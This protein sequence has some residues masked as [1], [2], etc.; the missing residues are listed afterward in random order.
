MRNI[1][2]LVRPH[3]L[4]MK[5][6]SS[7]R[8]E[9]KDFDKNLVFL[10]AN[11]SPF[12]NGLNRY[13][14]PQQV[15]VKTQLA[16]LKNLNQEQIFLGNGS[17]EVLDLIFR[18]FCDPNTDYVITLP[19]TYG[20][21]GVLAETNQIQNKEILLTTDFQPDTNTIL[22]ASNSHSKLLFLCS[23]NNPSG[24][25]FHK[26]LVLELIQNFPGIVVIDEAYVDFAQRPSWT[27]YLAEF[28][29]LIVV[30][31]LSKAHAHAGIRLGMALASPQIIGY[32]NKI[33]PPYNIN[34]LTQLAAVKVLQKTNEIT[35]QVK[36]LLDER[37]QLSVFLSTINFVEKV[38]PSEANFLLVKMDNAQLRYQQF[39]ERGVVLRDR[40]KQPLCE[41]TL[42]ITIGTPEENRVLREAFKRIERETQS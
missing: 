26:D 33:K 11:E 21:Y 2:K 41:N 15:T 1:S 12:T 16:R 40:S 35:E 19:P 17:D 31:T 20:M 7:A 24:N 36:V 32:L 30:Q 13:P 3:I 18:V 25:D 39:L 23:P 29:N 22:K 34:Q 28:E 9:F 37:E 38:F 27:N 5:P 6:Y 10:D 42:R 14:D 8:D 4:S